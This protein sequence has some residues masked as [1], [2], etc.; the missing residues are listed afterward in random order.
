MINIKKINIYKNLI[1][2]GIPVA[3]ENLVYSFINFV[4][5]FMVG[6]NVPEL[7]LGT[8]AVAALGISNQIFF[9]FIVSLFG[10]LSG[11][12][13]LSAQYYGS[14]NFEKLKKIL[15]FLM[16]A[17]L[18]F[19]I[20]F[21][22]VGNFYAKE[23]LSIYTK[24][25]GVLREAIKYFQISNFTFPIA[26]IGFALSMQLRVLQKSKYAFYASILGLF[27]N[28]FG[29]LL[30][31]PIIGVRGAAIA[32][33]LARLISAIYMVYA[34]KKNKLEIFGNIKE[35][36]YVEFELIKKILIISLPAFIH[37]VIWVLGI[38]FRTGLYSSVG[39]VEFAAIVTSVT[40]TSTL[41][42]MYSGISNATAV[43]IGS[44]LGA[45]NEKKA[46]DVAKASQVLIIITG[47]LICI[48]ITLVSP[49]V[50]SFMKIDNNLKELTLS[51][52]NFERFIIIIKGLNMIYI[53]GILRAGG[54]IYIPMIIDVLGIWAVSIPLTYFGK[55]SLLPISLIYLLSTAEELFKIVC[56]YYRYR[57]KKWLKKLI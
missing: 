52:L 50:L 56:S 31:I 51:I 36:F 38:N 39:T 28:I 11:A 53:I 37:E 57:N 42:S 30:L 33:I 3:L 16:I 34:I 48:I 22:I 8:N 43:S 1:Y 49:L 26:G 35:M 32:T 41:F 21:V 47:F 44:E 23:V 27:T 6:K 54:D 14:K 25:E 17:S 46:L 45:G 12:G 15:G 19:S 9:M 2:I 40:I 10:L 5:N 7:G 55:I 29:N 18:I 4:D 20:P 24:S 13:V